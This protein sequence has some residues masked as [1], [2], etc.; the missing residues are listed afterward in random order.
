MKLILIVRRTFSIG[1]PQTKINPMKYRLEIKTPPRNNQDAF[2]R[3]WRRMAVKQYP[4]ALDGN[5]CVYRTLDGNA[6]AVGYMLPARL[7]KG[8]NS[9]DLQGLLEDSP[10]AKRWLSKVDVS[11]LT[12][13]QRVHD[14]SVADGKP[15]SLAIT[16]GELRAIAK[17]YKLKVPKC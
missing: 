2:N 1:K 13:L 3:V 15:Q 10:A 12:D 7:F 4:R 8:N 9:I 17:L 11:L 16:K 6:C 14:F 5:A